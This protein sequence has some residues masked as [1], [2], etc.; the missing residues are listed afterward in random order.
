MNKYPKTLFC[1]YKG[2]TIYRTYKSTYDKWLDK[3]IYKSS[4][5]V[6]NLMF[7]TLEQCMSYI[8]IIN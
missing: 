4:Y 2:I 6:E 1:Y 3:Y 8:D 7:D 5:Y